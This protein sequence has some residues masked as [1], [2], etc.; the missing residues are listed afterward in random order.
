MKN[1]G[2]VLSKAEQIEEEFLKLYN[3]FCVFDAPEKKKASII[4]SFWGDIYKIVFKPL[5]DE[6]IYNNSKSRLK[7]YDVQEVQDVCEMYVK[8]CQRYGGVIKINQFSKLTGIHRYT[9]NIWHNA[10]K[11]NGYICRL[12]NNEIVEEN[13]SI[14]YILNNN[15]VDVVY[16]GNSK[17]MS[18]ENTK[19]LSSM[20]FDVVKKLREEMYDENTNSLEGT[21][22]GPLAR[23]NNDEDVGKMYDRQSN[24]NKVEAIKALS[25]T[26]LP[27]LADFSAE[28]T[29]EIECNND[30]QTLEKA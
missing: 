6:I 18:C 26:K 24:L 9:F 5:P 27:R 25:D 13:K 23:A 28:C 29:K 15:G 14:I 2:E 22:M 17:Y 8:L 12:N 19:E 7:T 1:K 4:D 3:D 11:T 20:R 10:N 30:K 21:S 16:N